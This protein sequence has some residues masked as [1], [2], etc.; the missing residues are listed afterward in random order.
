MSIALHFGRIV[1]NLREQHGLSQEVL[2]D[3]ADLNRSYVGEVERG[4][5][6]PSLATV[7]KIAKALNLPVSH[8]LAH[9]EAYEQSQKVV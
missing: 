4:T 8:L 7:A 2:A 9:Y 6:M 5:A 1:K 3:R